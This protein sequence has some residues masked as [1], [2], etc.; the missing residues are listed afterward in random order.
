MSLKK[1]SHWTSSN[2]QGKTLAEESNPYAHAL[3]VAQ[4]ACRMSVSY[5]APEVMSSTEQV[6]KSMKQELDEAAARAEHWDY[7]QALKTQRVVPLRLPAHTISIA[8]QLCEA[9]Q[10]APENSHVKLR[11]RN[12]SKPF[13]KSKLQL[14]TL[15]VT[16]GTATILGRYERNV[17]EKFTH[18][19]LH[20]TREFSYIL[21]KGVEAIKPWAVL[22][23][24]AIKYT[25]HESRVE[26][27]HEHRCI[28]ETDEVFLRESGLYLFI[29]YNEPDLE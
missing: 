21:D 10:Y 3:Q 7:I 2:N 16:D 27:V 9:A 18:E 15:S 20:T 25:G 19:L 24:P 11:V 13:N 5:P 4:D 29:P 8:R 28:M 14:E 26:Y 6:S 12:Q 22:D 1:H 17:P 23:L